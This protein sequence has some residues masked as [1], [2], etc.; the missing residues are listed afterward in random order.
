MPVSLAVVLSFAVGA[1]LS[2]IASMFIILRLKR[3]VHRLEKSLDREIAQ[4]S[5][6]TLIPNSLGK[7]SE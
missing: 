2:L 5:I 1:I 6:N 4:T 7:D 3:K